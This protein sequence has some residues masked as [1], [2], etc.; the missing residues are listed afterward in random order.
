MEPAGFL[1]GT[2]NSDEGDHDESNYDD[3]DVARTKT[4]RMTRTPK[5]HHFLSG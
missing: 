3:V 5:A 1:Y 2:G 4:T